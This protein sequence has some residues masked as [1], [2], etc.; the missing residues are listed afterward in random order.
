MIS[1]PLADFLRGQRNSVK[2]E[3]PIRIDSNPIDWAKYYASQ[4]DFILAQYRDDA[5]LPKVAGDVQLLEL[6]FGQ[7]HACSVK[8]LIDCVESQ[9]LNSLIYE[10]WA[11]EVGRRIKQVLHKHEHPSYIYDAILIHAQSRYDLD[12]TWVEA[13]E[14]LHEARKA[15]EG[16]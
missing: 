9:S 4:A 16:V 5:H 8:A 11:W 10:A 6:T 2:V 12:V 13:H 14:A 1:F 3:K 7:W 15:L